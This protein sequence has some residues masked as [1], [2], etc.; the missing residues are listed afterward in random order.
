MNGRRPLVGATEVVAR[1]RPARRA[2]AIAALI[3]LGL[4]AGV[5]LFVIV[6]NFGSFLVLVGLFAAFF[7]GVWVAL[8]RTE[9]WRWLGAAVGVLAGLGVF[10]AVIGIGAV[11]TGA[12]I[13]T[14]L[15]CLQFA[16]LTR[17]ALGDRVEVDL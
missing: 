1:Q 16:M 10:V 7:A 17:Y 8:A 13:V 14:F 5:V 9:W 6:T 4:I 3:T 12:T 15:L 11:A 2:A